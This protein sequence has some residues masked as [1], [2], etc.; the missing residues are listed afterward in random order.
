MR[1]IVALILL[2]W[3]M[4][5]GFHLGALVHLLLLLA[6]I[7]FILDLLGRRRPLD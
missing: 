2:L 3:L 5:W 7:V 1:V 6:V 4:G